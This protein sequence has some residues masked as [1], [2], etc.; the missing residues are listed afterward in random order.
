MDSTQAR[1]LNT[2]NVLQ[3]LRKEVQ[4]SRVAIAR[5][6]GL[7]RPTV[8]FII[9]QLLE[10]GIVQES[11]LAKSTGGRPPV[12]LR[13]TDNTRYVLGID[14]GSSHITVLRCDL[15][16]NQEQLL[17]ID[18]PV[19]E[20]PKGTLSIIS[21]IINEQYQMLSKTLLCLCFAVPSPVDQD[22]H[23]DPR[24]LPHWKGFSII[25]EFSSLKIP[26]LIEND[27]NAGAFAERWW[28]KRTHD[29][30]YVKLGTGIGAGIICDGNM[31]HGKQ[32]LVGEIG[33]LPIPGATCRCRCG[34]IGCLEAVIGRHA[35]QKNTNRTPIEDAEFIAEQIS[36]AILPLIY[37]LNPQQIILWGDIEVSV[38]HQL[39]KRIS[40]KTLWPSL[41]NMTVEVSPLGKNAIALG[42]CSIALNHLFQQPGLIANQPI[43]N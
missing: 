5:T 21:R 17:D 37:A 26:I 18:Y 7:S 36:F 22:L 24:V 13:L 16:G 1:Q 27:A 14:M 20:D 10:Q 31:L 41:T 39:Q 32:G 25:D 30:I 23:L 19:S 34:Q 35:L 29:F 15:N 9:N 8:T 43:H 3:T 40:A 33:H 4:V 2:L 12:V 38:P 28:S 42:A 6:L 11:H